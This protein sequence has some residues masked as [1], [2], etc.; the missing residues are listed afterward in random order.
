MWYRKLKS[1]DLRAD[2]AGVSLMVSAGAA[3]DALIIKMR[4]RIQCQ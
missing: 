2:S 1:K 3:C 4:A